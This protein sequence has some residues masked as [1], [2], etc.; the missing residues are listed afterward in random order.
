[1]RLRWW[2]SAGPE[3]G[4]G[5]GHGGLRY[6]EEVGLSPNTAGSHQRAVSRSRARSGLCFNGVPRARA[7]AVETGEA[8]GTGAS[9]VSGDWHC[10]SPW[11]PLSP[12]HRRHSCRM[13]GLHLYV[14]Q[15]V[16][17]H[18]FF[19]RFFPFSNF[20]YLVCLSVSLLKY[21]LWSKVGKE[22]RKERRR[23]IFTN[24]YSFL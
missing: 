13:S 22:E 16:L 24:E 5:P 14:L 15:C 20:S 12:C 3:S 21:M 17:R 8:R 9:W 19:H 11:G 4:E 10:T 2:R 18:L 6:P 1:M 7:M 23:E